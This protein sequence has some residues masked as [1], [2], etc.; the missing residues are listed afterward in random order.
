MGHGSAT[1]ER[2]IELIEPVVAAQGHELV[3]LDYK[4]A[5]HHSLLRVYI[6]RPGGTDIEAISKVS[7]EISNLLDVH[8]PIGNQFVFECSS[9]GIDRPLRKPA[10]YQRFVGERARVRRR[11]ALQG[12]RVLDGILEKADEAGIELALGEGAPLRL[13]YDD[14]ESAQ[15][16]RA[17]IPGFARGRS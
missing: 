13:P 10:D 7:R 9:P 6:D 17:E 8:D 11:G 5:G 1:R 15:L 12:D 4:P 16:L 3:E 14:I 2:L